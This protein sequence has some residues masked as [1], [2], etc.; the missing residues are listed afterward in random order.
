MGE[1]TLRLLIIRL[2]FSC[3]TTIAALNGSGVALSQPSSPLQQSFDI[4]VPW[5]PT[6]VVIGGKM[7]LVYELHLTNFASVD[8]SL[9]RI[10]VLDSAGVVLSD[11]KD[12]DLNGIIGRFDHM[13][14]TTSK[15]LIPPGVRVLAYLSVQLGTL[16]AYPI[17]LRH[18]IEYQAPATSDR[19]SVQG[20][21]FTISTEPPVAVGPPL[22]GGPWVPESATLAK[23]PARIE[24]E[25]ASGNYVALDLG[26]GHYAFYE[27]LK[28]ASIRVKPKDHVRRGSVIGLLGYTGESTGPHLHF[29]I[30]DNNS[31][32]NAEGLPY[33]L[34][35]FKI[36]GAYPS[37]ETFGK[38]LSWSPALAGSDVKPSG[39]FPAPLAVVD[40]P[41]SP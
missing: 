20:G 24:P 18:R 17:T 38:S 30:S 34:Q 19:A 2:V 37:I 16:G 9:K 31:P 22:R 8:L 7:Q 6:P 28:P 32:L 33:Q 29:H 15:L 3:S 26:A 39:E 25:Y 27:H 14:P 11:L 41:D 23:N 13:A 5:R 36:L 4:Q 21:A 10:E 40:F 35:G 12:S 1:N